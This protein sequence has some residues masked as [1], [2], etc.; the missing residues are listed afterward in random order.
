MKV[1]E[2]VEG[3]MPIPP[4]TVGFNTD[5]DFTPKSEDS[6]SSSS[7]KFGFIDASRTF[8]QGKVPKQLSKS[9]FQKRKRQTSK[10]TKQVPKKYP[11]KHDLVQLGVAKHRTRRKFNLK[12]DVITNDALLLKHVPI[13][14]T[15]VEP[16]QPLLVPLS[17][18][19]HILLLQKGKKKVLLIGETH[20][21]SFFG[22]KGYVPLSRIIVDYLQNVKQKVDFMFEVDETI[23]GIHDTPEYVAAIASKAEN[24]SQLYILNQVRIL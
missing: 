13:I 12:K 19:D 3:V 6:S 10:R 11:P 23:V 18:V 14:A 20:Q 21:L 5:G 7:S 1:T 15:N 4:F 2:A 16:F 9:L 22:D 24:E 8:F 17:G